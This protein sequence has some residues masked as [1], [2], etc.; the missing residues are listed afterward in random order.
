VAH[1]DAFKQELHSINIDYGYDTLQMSAGALAI[2]GYSCC[3]GGRR[4]IRHQ[5]HLSA[6][7][8][9]HVDGSQAPARR[10]AVGTRAPI[11]VEAR[12]NAR[13]SLD[14]VHDQFARGRRFPYANCC[15]SLEP[16]SIWGI[17]DQAQVSCL[18]TRTHSARDLIRAYSIADVAQPIFD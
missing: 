4:A 10:R 1:G 18:S 16:V 7:P 5:P 13:R 14:F 9:G 2:G 3:C 17:L 8:G 11:L 15:R 12:P 6:L